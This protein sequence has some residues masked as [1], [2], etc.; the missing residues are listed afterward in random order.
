MKAGTAQEP[1]VCSQFFIATSQ[2]CR[3]KKLKPATA[4]AIPTAAMSSQTFFFA[5]KFLIM[6]CSAAIECFRQL[7]SL[8][9]TVLQTTSYH[10]YCLIR[11]RTPVLDEASCLRFCPCD[12]IF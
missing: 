8:Y 10:R 5:R 11:D 7:H 1:R 2:S 12:R 3:G 4:I 6:R 9:V